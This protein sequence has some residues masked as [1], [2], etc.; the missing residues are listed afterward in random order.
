MQVLFPL[1]A[2]VPRREVSKDAPTGVAAPLLGSEGDAEQ[3]QESACADLLATQSADE[4]AQGCDV[5]DGEVGPPGT[6]PSRHLASF[7]C[8]LTVS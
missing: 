8:C 4:Y 7:I 2:L 5:A 3:G 6:I 1:L